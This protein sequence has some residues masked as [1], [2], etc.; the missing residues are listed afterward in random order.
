MEEKEYLKFS[1]SYEDE[2]GQSTTLNK[3]VC[4]NVLEDTNPL[5]LLI[6]NFKL[7]LLD[8]GF[9]KDSINKISQG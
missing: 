6:D 4:S 2:Y 9:H 1:F 8:C 3:T 5:N 7:F